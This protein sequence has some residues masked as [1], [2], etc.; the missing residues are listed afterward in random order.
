MR[1]IFE[2]NDYREFLDFRFKELKKEKGIYSFRYLASK[3]KCSPGFLKHVIDGKRNLNMQMIDAFASAF[4]MTL[5]EKRFFTFLVILSMCEEEFTRNYVLSIISRMRRKFE[6]YPNDNDSETYDMGSSDVNTWL[7]WVI[8]ELTRFDNF[9]PELGWIKPHLCDQ[10]IK[11][12]EILDAIN[13][14][15]SSQVI[16]FKDEKYTH[17]LNLEEWEDPTSEV[18]CLSM[19][20]QLRKAEM[21]LA[22]NM[23]YMPTNFYLSSLAINF[24]RDME[25]IYSACENFYKEIEEI[26][27]NAI[28]P[29]M[30]LTMN[31]MFYTLA[32]KGKSVKE[33]K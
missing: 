28:A 32:R 20:T 25:K 15:L 6:L 22:D 2:F 24:D 23:K 16:V 5:N 12:E 4:K 11:D 19:Q 1:A 9:K 13:K 10:E 7:C 26:H 14:L 30:V 31:N 33:E 29:D 3:I 8:I 27:A 18:D 21:V 17:N